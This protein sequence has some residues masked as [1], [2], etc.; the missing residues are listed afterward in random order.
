MEAAGQETQEQLD[1]VVQEVAEQLETVGQGVAEQSETVGQGVEEQLETV[2]RQ[3]QRDDQHWM[4]VSDKGF[5]L[6]ALNSGNIFISDVE[7][8]VQIYIPYERSCSL[9]F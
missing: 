8:S 1:T 3:V 2:M 5:S 7:R 9:V 4:A 6:T